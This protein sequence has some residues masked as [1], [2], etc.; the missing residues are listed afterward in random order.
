MY[1][2]VDPTTKIAN[3]E[4]KISNMNIPNSFD[5]NILSISD[6]ENSLSLRLLFSKVKLENAVESES[7]LPR[8]LLF[9]K[10]KKKDV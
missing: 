8:L 7:K 6:Y 10:E 5:Q 2:T 4:R 3:V 1:S 9:K